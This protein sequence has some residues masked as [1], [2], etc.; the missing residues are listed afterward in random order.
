MSPKLRMGIP[1]ILLTLPLLAIPASSGS[2]LDGFSPEERALIE[3]LGLDLNVCAGCLRESSIG[4]QTW[5]SPWVVEGTVAGI[6]TDP[7]DFYPTRVRLHVLRYLKGSGGWSIT[8]SF[9][10]GPVYSERYH[11]ILQEIS[12]TV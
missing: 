11:T 3:K 4:T 6:D 12:P 8:L 9:M 10:Y 7:H 2:L 5:L 1:L